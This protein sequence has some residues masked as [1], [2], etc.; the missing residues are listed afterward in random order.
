MA[1]IAHTPSDQSAFVPPPVSVA[2]AFQF[3]PTGRLSVM[4]NRWSDPPLTTTLAPPPR[5]DLPAEQSAVTLLKSS[6]FKSDVAQL[7][8]L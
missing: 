7:A 1:Q 4:L 2:V 5:I 3:A 8:S 6:G